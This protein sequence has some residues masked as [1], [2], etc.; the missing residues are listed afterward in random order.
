M[1]SI[2][3]YGIFIV[4]DWDGGWRVTSA[5]LVTSDV[6]LRVNQKPIELGGAK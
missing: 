5:L 2:R 1:Q 3:A 6:W 4:S